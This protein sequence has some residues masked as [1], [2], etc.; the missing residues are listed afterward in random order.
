MS[1]RTLSRKVA[2]EAAACVVEQKPWQRRG[3]RGVSVTVIVIEIVRI[4]QETIDWNDSLESAL[5]VAIAL[6]SFE[7]L[8]GMFR[9]IGCRLKQLLP[10]RVVLT[11]QSGG[12]RAVFG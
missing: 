11:R 1:K 9:S 3:R 12:L 6:L 7:L 8:L 10:E 5:A 4:A 2:V